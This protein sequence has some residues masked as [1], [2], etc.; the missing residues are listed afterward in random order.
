MRDIPMPA[1]DAATA[2]E[3]ISRIGQLT[4]MLRDSMRELGL[5]QAIAQA[6]EAI[7]DARD[8]LDYVVTMTAQAA[9]RALNCVEAAQPR[10]AELESE[11][12]ALKGR[13]DDWFADPIELAD[14]RALVTDT[15]QYLEQVP[16]HTAFTNAQLLE[17]MMA[18]D[19]EGPGW[20]QVI[21]RMMD[22]V[23]E[24]EKQLLMVLMENIPEQ[25]AKEKKPNDSL[26]NG[27]QLDQNGAGVIANQAQ[28]DDL[29]DSL[30]F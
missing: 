28:V 21:K 30:G 9:E 22:V 12:K 11:A 16:E 6:A 4:R 27:P 1:S 8:R 2:G 19:F 14:A 3:I 18:Q 26:L 29:L 7:P 17:I 13:W 20:E 25:P 15:R 23:Q 24:I 5:D 10:Q